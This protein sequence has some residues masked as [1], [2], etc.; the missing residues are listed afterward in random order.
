[1]QNVAALTCTWPSVAG[2]PVRTSAPPSRVGKHGTEVSIEQQSCEIP[3]LAS[4]QF[5]A[6][7]C[8]THAVSVQVS[9]QV[10]ALP[11]LSSSIGGPTVPPPARGPTSVD[12]PVESGRSMASVPTVPPV[13]PS[14][15]QAL[16]SSCSPTPATVTCASTVHSAPAFAAVL[17]HV[18]M[19][20]IPPPS[21][22]GM[23]TGQT[24]SKV[25]R[26]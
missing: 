14:G 9:V 21:L 6:S 19:L 12:A 10:P 11:Q 3:P 2:A 24:S 8:S 4:M 1:M 26:I 13:S 17:E 22:V 20:P 25:V 16:D 15:T 7:S 5:P 23:Q 18:P